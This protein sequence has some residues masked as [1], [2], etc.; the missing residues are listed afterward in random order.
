MI[1]SSQDIGGIFFN[2]AWFGFVED[3]V[4]PLDAGR[5][6]VRIIGIHG[7]T[8]SKDVLPWALVNQPITSAAHVGV[9]SSPTGVVEGSQVW[10]IFLDGAGQQMPMVIGSIGGM[11]DGVSDINEIARGINNLDK[12]TLPYEPA[13]QYNAKY[14]YNKTTTT[15]GGHV[16]EY[17]D[18]PGAERIHIYHKKGSYSEYNPDGSYVHR[19]AGDDYDIILQNKTLYVGGNLKI[20]TEGT[21]EIQSV[22]DTTIQTE[23]EATVM[24]EKSVTIKAPEITFMETDTELDLSV[25]RDQSYIKENGAIAI[26]D[27]EIPEGGVVD[28]T[29]LSEFPP[30]SVGEDAVETGD[31]AA[32]QRSSVRVSCLDLDIQGTS[33]PRGSAIYNTKLSRNFTLGQMSTGTVLSKS[34][35]RDQVGLKSADIVCNLKAVA[36]NILEPLRARYPGFTINSGFRHGSGMSQHNKGQAVDLQWPSMTNRQMFEVAQWAARNLPVD[37]LIVEHGNKIWLHISYNRSASRQRGKLTTM[38]NNRY[39]NGLTLHYR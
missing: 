20:V 33:I 16:I 36:E 31:Q 15:E 23:G 18:T 35:I 24:S 11:T 27:D 3:R 4:D 1:N 7:D 32:E 34:N 26:F 12:G 6:K 9:G 38:I 19:T 21:T 22:G 39:T 14:P 29:L 13:S 25:A 5:L 37:Q 30:P 28:S 17:D 10:G 2:A 8:V